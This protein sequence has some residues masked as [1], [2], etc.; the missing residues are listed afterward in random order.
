MAMIACCLATPVAAVVFAILF[1]L[2]KDFGIAARY[3]FFA[4]AG[5]CVAILLLQA[6][7]E[8]VQPAERSRW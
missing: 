7:Y 1:A 8:L 4:G 3:A 5:V 2:G 6:A